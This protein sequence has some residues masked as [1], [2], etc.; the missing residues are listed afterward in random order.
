MSGSQRK[1]ATGDA[2]E[3]E[4]NAAAL[5]EIT[6]FLEKQGW[7]YCLIGGLAASYWGQ[8]RSTKDVDLVLLAGI[9]DEERFIK[10][11]TAAFPVRVAGA[12]KFAIVSRVVLLQT[13]SG[14]GI[15]VS[16]GALPFEEE[17]MRRAK[18]KEVLPGV[19][20]RTA[21]AEDVV[22][23]KTIAGRPRDV[24]DIERIIAT[25]GKKLDSAYIR[26]WLT[27]MSEALSETDLVGF[28]ENTVRSVS[29]RMKK[30][31][32]GKLPRDG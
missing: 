3:R 17:M 31:P 7:Q 15:D 9:G 4:R 1:Q 16:L 26:C 32:R 14:V 28:F 30:T 20:V 12:D 5:A 6:T 29:D 10:P 8:P 2:Q 18:I 11:L 23:M 25:Q 27:E 19:R 22:V 24:D 13:K 21:T